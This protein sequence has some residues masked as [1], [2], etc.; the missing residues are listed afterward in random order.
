MQ[1]AV[2][3]LRFQTIPKEKKRYLHWLCSDLPKALSPKY[4]IKFAGK[5]KV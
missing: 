4:W 5:T 1:E 2:K 3:Y